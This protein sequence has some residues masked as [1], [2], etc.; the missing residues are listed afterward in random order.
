MANYLASYGREYGTK[1]AREVVSQHL[2]A[3]ES[4][5]D[6]AIDGSKQVVHDLRCK[7]QEAA[8]TLLDRVN[9]S[10]EKQRPRIE[11]Y[12]EAHPWVVLGGVILLAYVFS[13]DQRSD[14]RAAYR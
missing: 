14:Q 11:A 12:M 10:W 2:D 9:R 13:A 3:V 5:V 1:D 4:G 7:A 6:N 8:D